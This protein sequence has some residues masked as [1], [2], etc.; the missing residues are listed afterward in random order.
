M[1]SGDTS[2][3]LAG[4]EP[5]PGEVLSPEPE[6][7]LGIDPEPE[8]PLGIDPEPEPPL[9]IL[10]PLLGEVVGLGVLWAKELEIEASPVKANEPITRDAITDFFITKMPLDIGKQHG[11]VNQEM[12]GS[13]LKILR[14]NQFTI[15]HSRFTS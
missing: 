10:D 4:M 15:Q 5:P 1:V 9:G 6:P 3:V 13:N 12:S 2:G 14:H 11:L 8:P 7:P